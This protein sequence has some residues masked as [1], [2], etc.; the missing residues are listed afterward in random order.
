MGVPYAPGDSPPMTTTAS[1]VKTFAFNGVALH[2]REHGACY[3]LPA[4]E[5]AKALGYDTTDAGS[6]SRITEN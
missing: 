6:V 4:G 2:F 5:V 3:W 1:L